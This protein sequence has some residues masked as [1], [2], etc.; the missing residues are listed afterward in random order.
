MAID[1]NNLNVVNSATPGMQGNPAPIVSPQSSPWQQ[2]MPPPQ[3]Q[4]VAPT[5]PPSAEELIL[6]GIREKTMR[7]ETPTKQEQDFIKGM[8][9][10]H[11][12]N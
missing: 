3:Q 4:Q 8:L 11:F 5:G 10:Q 6:Q 7:G 12:D 9:K 2:L 1:P